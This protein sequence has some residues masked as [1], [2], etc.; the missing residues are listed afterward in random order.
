LL[1]EVPRTRFRFRIVSRPY[2]VIGW[3]SSKACNRILRSRIEAAQLE[4]GLA[5]LADVAAHSARDYRYTPGAGAQAIAAFSVMI[6]WKTTG[7]G[8][9]A[10][11]TMK[12]SMLKRPMNLPYPL[13]PRHETNLASAD[14]A[15]GS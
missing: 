8:T 5:R 9:L 4:L 14:R 15:Q 12:V 6:T 7:A 2:R 10:S 1:Y 13:P 3:S 11:E